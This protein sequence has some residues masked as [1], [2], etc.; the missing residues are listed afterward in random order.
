[1]LT[2]LSP[3][4][5]A[6][7]AP[8]GFDPDPEDLAK[9][10][11]VL[12]NANWPDEN[13]D[14]V[15]DSEEVARFYAAKRGIPL[16]NLVALNCSPTAH[17]YSGQAGWEAFWDEMVLPV[18]DHIENVVGSRVGVG[19]LVFCYGVP[20]QINPPGWSPRGLD[21]TMI[22]LWAL[23][24]RTSPAYSAY[25]S[26][27]S[28]HD[29][30]PT[31]GNDKERFDPAN[32][33]F[34]GET[35]YIC[36]RLDGLNV[37][38]AKE[39]VEYALY[40]DAYISPQPG[41]HQGF[42]YADTRYGAYTWADLAGYPYGHNAYANADKDMAYGRQWLDEM[43]FVLRWE[44]YGTEIGE[45]GAKY[46]DGSSAETAPEAM[47]YEGW[48]N[49][50]KYQD[51]F[52][53]LVGSTACDLNSNSIA[54]IRQLNPGTFLG[55]SFQLGLAAGVGCIA[56][57][58]LNGH[59]FPEVFQHYMLVKGYTFGE[60]ARISD[61]KLLWTNL[62]V[63]DLLYQPM[64]PGKIA[65]L[66]TQAPPPSVVSETA[67]A[68][69]GERDFSTYLDTFG[70]LPDVGRMQLEYGATPALGQTL[71]ADQDRPRVYHTATMTGLSADQLVHYRADYTDPAGN[72]GLGQEYI[73]HTALDATPVLARV[74][75][76]SLSLPAGSSFEIELVYGAQA[77][78][79]TLTSTT[80]TV[81]SAAMGW[82]QYDLGGRLPM[83]NPTYYSSSQAKLQS[84]RLTVPGILP[85]GSYLIEVTATSPAGSDS[86]SITI[87]LY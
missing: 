12:Y 14:G 9:R 10:V 45:A 4:V 11:L 40:G 74:E 16:G 77:G 7:L 8:Q 50:N 28:Y 81:T 35:S 67:G 69:A 42:A 24:T 86:H 34:G 49:Y 65:L 47:F 54:R 64:R 43:G 36:A 82:T 5:L 55:E 25:G 79:A 53:W 63:G 56:E 3:L 26:F 76:E 87:D 1:M 84:A 46:E 71:Y 15:G 13:G 73:L 2:L 21:T 52:E 30:A 72:L 66:D 80:A 32:R 57:P 23:G 31:V 20:Y 39:L 75:T 27:N 85:V 70:V 37:E 62:Y 33:N 68:V 60:A 29:P 41:Y 51:V 22:G 18:R 59:P 61:P 6:A 38:H 58:Y 17:Y 78:A 44:P 83:L 48:Y 19:G